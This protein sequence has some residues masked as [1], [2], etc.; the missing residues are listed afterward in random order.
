MRDA[1]WS[2]LAQLRAKDSKLDNTSKVLMS[3]KFP[4]AQDAARLAESKKRVE[5]PLLKAIRNFE[6]SM[7]EDTVRN[8]Y[9]MHHQIHEWFAGEKVETRNVDTLN[10]KVYAD[11]FLTPR[12]DPWLGLR[13]SGVYSALDGEG[14]SQ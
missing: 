4:P 7:A 11:L 10:E 1:D 3:Q 5:S 9:L 13:T 12:T 6:R 8:E 14:W 2:R